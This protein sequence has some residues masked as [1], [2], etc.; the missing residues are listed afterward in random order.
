MADSKHAHPLLRDAPSPAKQVKD[1]QL[2]QEIMK[3]WLVKPDA[4][5]IPFQQVLPSTFNRKGGPLNTCYIA[6]DL[7]PRIKDKG[8]APDRA[9]I[10][11]VR[12]VSLQRRELVI[13]HAAGMRKCR[14]GHYAPLMVPGEKTL[15]ECVG[16]N[17]VT[18]TLSNFSA[19]LTAY[20]GFIFQAP[21][22]DAELS[23]AMQEGHL[24][25]VLKED[26]PDIYLVFLSEYLNA[27]QN[28]D[29]FNSEMHL[30]ATVRETAYK[31]LTDKPHVTTGEIIAQ[32]C[33]NSVVRLRADNVGDQAIW[34]VPFH[35]S[36]Q[37]WVVA[38]RREEE[39]REEGWRSDHLETLAQWHASN[40]NPKELTVS[41]RFFAEVQ[42]TFGREVPIVKCSTARV[43]YSGEVKL[44]QTRPT[45]DCSRTVSAA[46]MQAA[47][48]QGLPLRLEADLQHVRDVVLPIMSNTTDNDEALRL[49]WLLEDAQVRLMFAKT[50]G[51]VGF[52]HRVS[53]KH[54]P[55]KQ[56][57]LRADWARH[58][59]AVNAAYTPILD[60]LG[61]CAE[62]PEETDEVLCP[63]NF[64]AGKFR[65]DPILEE[66]A[67]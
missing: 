41:S 61:V 52:K 42:T 47:K 48:K 3:V 59:V 63:G 16:G 58:C 45:P 15:Y 10:G 46:D 30:Q 13:A 38:G 54:T 7:G 62:A 35:G 39:G 2:Y 51:S 50:L 21:P 66:L 1:A 37:G 9:G 57:A 40:V 14:A 55:E 5:R 11:M 28:Q 36:L 19:R 43:H 65:Q 20:N 33:S 18:C 31:L 26:T 23:L 29:Q 64:V 24:Y 4:Q 44:R 32:V 17:H 53:G 49:V 27:A 22:D 56:Q 34:V 6:E 25:F 8:F 12:K 60:I 67:D